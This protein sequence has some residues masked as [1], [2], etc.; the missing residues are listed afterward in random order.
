MTNKDIKLVQIEKKLLWKGLEIVSELTVGGCHS[1]VYKIINSM[2]EEEVIKIYLLLG[3]EEAIKRKMRIYLREIG[4]MSKLSSSSCIISYKDSICCPVI[5]STKDVIVQEII[6][7]MQYATNLEKSMRDG[8]HFSKNDILK[9]GIDICQA[10]SNCM[11]ICGIMHR[12]IKPFNLYYKGD[13]FLLGDF[14][15]AVIISNNSEY[16][17][18]GTP[19]YS[20]PE[21]CLA[22]GRELLSTYEVGLLGQYY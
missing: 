14:G 11:K 21:I 16:E 18:L 15:T 7:R 5:N 4:Y 13:N 20:A 2:G 22:I 19:P 12:D 10:L 3:Q 9:L 1:K 8:K 17:P 6:I